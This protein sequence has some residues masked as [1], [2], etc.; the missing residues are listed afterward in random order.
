MKRSRLFPH[1]PM[2]QALL[3]ILLLCGCPKKAMNFGESGEPRT[4][5]ELL[6]RI[7]VAED[8][9]YALDGDAKL[10]VDV[11]QGKGTVGL[12]V[13]ALHPDKIHVEQLDFFNRPQRVLI[14]DGTGFSLSDLGAQAYYR[15]KPTAQNIHR[16]LPFALPLKELVALVLGRVPRIPHENAEMRLDAD[17]GRFQLTLSKGEIHQVLDIAT[18]SYRIVKSVVTGTNAYDFECAETNGPKDIS[19][20]STVTMVSKAPKG[21]MQIIAKAL[22]YNESIDITLFESG[23]PDNVK[24]IDLDALP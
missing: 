7:A 5:E 8:S 6:R 4:A 18:P 3:A 24:V 10:F 13:A 11:E 15:G 14:S 22:R 2:L 23:A 19:V 20:C 12:F 9:V 16:F 21:T 17:T 1:V